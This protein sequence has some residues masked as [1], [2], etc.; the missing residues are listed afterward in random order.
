MVATSPRVYLLKEFYSF[1]TCDAAHENARGATLV[2]L[3]IEKYKS[4]GSLSDSSR[5]GLV[6][7]QSAI[8]EALQERIAPIR[9]V[10]WRECL[11]LDVHGLR[12]RSRRGLGIETWVGR[13][14]I[15]ASIFFVVDRG[16]VEVT[17]KDVRGDRSLFGRHLC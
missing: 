6:W 3:T 7:G 10:I 17:D 8:D 15:R 4:L 13:G 14:K 1:L 9:Q 11:G 12:L 2:Y 5:L 16:L